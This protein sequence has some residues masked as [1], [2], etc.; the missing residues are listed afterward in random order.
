MHGQGGQNGRTEV[1]EKKHWTFLAAA[2]QYVLVE[3]VFEKKKNSFQQS[4]FFPDF[5]RSYHCHYPGKTFPILITFQI[6]LELHCRKPP[7]FPNVQ[8]TVKVG[9][10]H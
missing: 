6:D 3:H 7:L 5:H 2:H 8:L 10:Y 4:H 9:Q 1:E